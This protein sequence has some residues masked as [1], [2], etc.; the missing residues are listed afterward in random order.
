MVRN[1]LTRLQTAAVR[2]PGRIAIGAAVLTV[3]ALIAG[4]QVQFRT[5]RAELAP[6]DDPD[7]IRMNELLAENAGTEALIACVEG[8]TGETP[9][10]MEIQ[11]FVNRLAEEFAADERVEHV[12]HR[13]DVDWFLER[14]LYLLPTETL[15]QLVAGVQAQ[16]GLL[17]R[18]P[19]VTD[20]A[21]LDDL[22]AD[23]I[24][25]G[26]AAG[27]LSA[28]DAEQ[29]VGALTGLAQLLEA[30]Q[31]FIEDPSGAT[32]AVANVSP[33][34]ALAGDRAAMLPANGYLTTYDAATYFIVITPRDTSDELDVRRAMVGSMRERAATVQRLSPGFHVA[35]TGQPAVVVEE[36]DT[37]RRDTWITSAIAVIGVTLLTML[38][39][40]WR[41]H[42]FL[43]LAA[44]A[45]GI[46]LAFGA[47]LFEF[48]YLNMITSSF[49]STLVGLGVA[50]GIHPVSE[51]ELAGAHTEDPEATI[52][53]SFRRTGAG[54]TVAA[55]TTAAAFLSIWLMRF[56]GF[57][58]LGVVAGVGVLLCL[59]AA[60]IALPAFLALYG[61]WRRKRVAGGHRRAAV[62]DRVWVEM[63]A[64]KICRSP[65]LVMLAAVLVTA[66]AG[67]AA[68]GLTFN[69]NILE[70]LPSKAES[71]RYQNRMLMQS[72]L[73]PFYNIV[74]AEDLAGLNE[75]AGRAALEPAVARFESPLDFLPTDIQTA[76]QLIETLRPLVEPIRLADAARELT[77]ER[78]ASSLE[79]LEEQLALST[80]DAFVAGLADLVEPLERA[81]TA[82]E[83]CL[84]QARAAGPTEV[85]AW[86]AAQPVLLDAARHAMNQLRR[87]LDSSPPTPDNL[88]REL[89]LRFFTRSGSML[90]F[91]HPTGEIFDPEDLTE[92]VAAS[93][94]VDEK[95]TGFPL[96]FSKMSGRITGG[97]YRA[98]AVGALL[99]VLI[100]IIDFRSLRDAFLALVPLVLGVI[101][102]MGAMR[103]FEIPFNFANLVAVPL[104]IGV[105]IDNGVHVIHR[106]RLE[107]RE[108]MNVV[109]RH[110][111]RA[112]MVASA[113][114]M[115][116]F[117]SLALAS[118]RGLA[119]LGT[120]L[121][122][123]VGSCLITSTVVLPNLLVTFGLVE[124]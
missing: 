46:S 78:L 30:Q 84:E 124:R 28:A 97:F 63:V 122:L 2:R 88:P 45:V 116:G 23:Q 16:G 80:E 6:A 98:V 25:G 107:G 86:N 9:S 115:I 114:T 14:G 35:F 49:I 60:V 117:G 10:T 73:A 67:W 90:G 81:R 110:T 108:G 105:G 68:S 20:L 50:Y 51:Y 76:Q 7:Q 87:N 75:M 59:A 112:I 4:S 92:F 82:A 109:L 66:V 71:V 100:L 99:V 74:V 85:A 70:L 119:S 27:S 101:W 8:A 104:I 34:L 103:L 93:R 22:I 43:V 89:R 41:S 57:A 62:V 1:L 32:E 91:L 95:A 21:A 58:E 31:A 13:I 11:H 18:L 5:S 111:G 69:T 94:R 24:A 106:V 36:M 26:R 37:V 52:V 53:E 39:F 55:V 64:G 118:H 47:V 123:G 79:R 19:E 40:R 44:L 83:N 77:S 29:A 61:N 72:D 42:A 102:M 56:R 65:R 15:R 33:L 113:T 12:F 121:L 38:V 48:G 3:L 120:V 96:V 54:V 17:E